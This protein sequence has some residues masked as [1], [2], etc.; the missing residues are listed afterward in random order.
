[1][2]WPMFVVDATCRLPVSCR[3]TDTPWCRV[4]DDA[5]RRVVERRAGD[6]MAAPTGRL[7][8]GCAAGEPGG[9]GITIRVVSPDASIVRATRLGGA[10]NAVALGE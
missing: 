7:A 6:G 4:I 10:T 5:A 3:R 2:R 1:M 8:A 9:T